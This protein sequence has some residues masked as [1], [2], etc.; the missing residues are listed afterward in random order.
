MNYKS[1][2]SFISHQVSRQPIRHFAELY[3]IDLSGLKS[4]TQMVER[5]KE[6]LKQRYDTYGDIKKH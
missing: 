1:A 2:I 5:I 4:N 3:D 6:V